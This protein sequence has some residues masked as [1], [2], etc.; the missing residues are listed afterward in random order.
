[1]YLS[2]QRIGT[3]FNETKKNS[4]SVI[5]RLFCSS[6]IHI[7]ILS[8]VKYGSL[9]LHVHVPIPALYI[10]ILNFHLLTIVIHFLN[11]YRLHIKEIPSNINKIENY[12]MQLNNLII[13]SEENQIL[14]RRS[15]LNQIQFPV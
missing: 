3:F 4:D 8:V 15:T 5:L 13:A 10:F 9:L 12:T 14:Q 2:M 1:M 11:V 7:N 6:Q